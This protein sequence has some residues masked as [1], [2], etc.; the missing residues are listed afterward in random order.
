MPKLKPCPFCG[1]EA[2]TSHGVAGMSG[3]YCFVSCEKC[4]SKTRRF[5]VW[6]NEAEQDAIKVW[7]TRAKESDSE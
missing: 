7:N 1:G 4:Q 3:R 6:N 5:F 2:T